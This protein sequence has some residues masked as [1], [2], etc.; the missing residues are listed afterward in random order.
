MS[1]FVLIFLFYFEMRKY[2]IAFIVFIFLLFSREDIPLWFIF[3]FLVLIIWHRKERRIV[4]FCIAGII[5]SIAYFILLFKVLL[6]MVETSQLQYRGVFQY[7]ILGATPWEAFV[8]ILKHPVDTFELLYKNPDPEHALD[9]IKKEFYMVYLISGAFLLFLRPQ[10]FIWF[11]PLI[12]EKMLNDVYERWSIIGYYA[13]QVIVLL[14]VSVFLI[15]SIFQAKWVRYSLAGLVCM[16]AF[17]VTYTKMNSANL[18]APW[19]YS[20]KENILDSRFFYSDYNAA[21]IH[22]DLKMIPT[23]AKVCASSSILPHL[24][25]RKYAYE[26]PDVED[27]DYIAIFTFKDFYVVDEKDYFNDVAQYVLDPSWKMI[28]YD[29]PFLL[30]KKRVPGK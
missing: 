21:K 17:S 4:W 22:R 29:P 18:A 19:S 30:M 5:S 13:D 1:Y 26:F 24:S 23:D 9:D 11:I 3:I 28:A 10:Y 8:H 2:V 27:A 20:V 6:P 15:I 16:L 25:E 7:S 14:P 12:A